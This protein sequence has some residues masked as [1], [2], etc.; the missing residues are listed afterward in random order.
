MISIYRFS[1]IVYHTQVF[2]RTKKKFHFL[3][4]AIQNVHIH[5]GFP[6]LCHSASRRL[7][8]HNSKNRIAPIS[9]ITSDQSA[10]Y[11]HTETYDLQCF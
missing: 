8:S 1:F 10:R 9:A 6:Y 7:R 11:L 2:F 3:L 5:N 4:K